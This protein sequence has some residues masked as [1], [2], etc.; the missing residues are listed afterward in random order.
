MVQEAGQTFRCHPPVLQPGPAT[1]KGWLWLWVFSSHLRFSEPNCKK[2]PQTPHP[3]QSRPPSQ[4]G[5]LVKAVTGPRSNPDRAGGVGSMPR[6]E[7]HI[8]EAE[9]APSSPTFFQDPQGTLICSTFLRE[10]SSSSISSHPFHLAYALD[11]TFKKS[12][13]L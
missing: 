9:D 7:G 8:P 12:P 10:V 1:V 11:N 5:R 13:I 3:S 2:P 6:K 4:A